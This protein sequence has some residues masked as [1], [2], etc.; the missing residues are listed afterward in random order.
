MRI[1]GSWLLCEDGVTRPVVRVKVLGS[2]GRSHIDDFLIDS[3]ADRTVFSADVLK[4]LQFTGN[5]S[6]PG[7][8]L[9]GIGGESPFLLVNAIV[10]LTRDDGKPTRVHGEYAALTNPGATDLSILGRDV[11]YNFDLIL[12]R[13]HKEVLLLAPNHHY[14]VEQG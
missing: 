8:A 2:D 10:E 9:R 11:L 7:F 14:C 13:C 5:H 1:V 6:H 4:G 3:A 12:G